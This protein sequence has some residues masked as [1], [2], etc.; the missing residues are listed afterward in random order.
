MITWIVCFMSSVIVLLMSNTDK[1]IGSMMRS[2][3][4]V[5]RHLT[6]FSFITLVISGG[7][8]W[9]VKEKFMKIKCESK[10]HHYGNIGQCV[11]QMG[12]ILAH[13]DALLYPYALHY[14]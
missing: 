1:S 14:I 3:K 7:R 2:L 9:T 10:F 6:R 8:S 11:D 5:T 4:R 12:P 13:V